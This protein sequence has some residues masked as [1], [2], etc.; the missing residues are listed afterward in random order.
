MYF[1][2]SPFAFFS[3][4]QYLRSVR[5]NVK[6]QKQDSLQQ[7]LTEPVGRLIIKNAVPTVITMMI[8]AIYNTAD[9][10]F[11]SKLGTSASGAVGVIFTLMFLMQA[12]AFTIGMGS[13]SIVSRALGSENFKKANVVCSTAIFTAFYYLRKYFQG[14]SCPPS[15]GDS[16]DSSVCG[17]LCAI[18]SFRCAVHHNFVCHE[19][20]F[21]LSGA[22]CL[23]DGRNDFGR[24]PEHDS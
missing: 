11:V 21:A 14:R 4:F 10:Y 15:R 5:Y 18:H 3:L 24:N 12:C 2:Y 17:R 8:T 1:S 22:C 19:Q 6:M 20:P 7:M 9:T 13:G 23:L 16:D